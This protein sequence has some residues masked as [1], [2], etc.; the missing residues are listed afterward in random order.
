MLPKWLRQA[1]KDEVLSE[2]EAQELHQV[3]LASEQEEASLPEHLWPA[4][5]RVHLWEI[6]CS[7]T[8]H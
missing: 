6:P 3:A 1:I 2:Q 7:A 4:A 8:L 5:A